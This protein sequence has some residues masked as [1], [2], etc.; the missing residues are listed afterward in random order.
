MLPVKTRQPLFIGRFDDLTHAV[1]R[2]RRAPPEGLYSGADFPRFFSY[3]LE[4]GKP[5]REGR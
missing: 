2:D 5:I 3:A 1:A 4:F